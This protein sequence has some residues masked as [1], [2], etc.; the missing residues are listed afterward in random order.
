MKPNSK[1]NHFVF[2]VGRKYNITVSSDDGH[3]NTGSGAVY[4]GASGDDHEFIVDGASQVWRHETKF[5][6]SG[7]KRFTL[8]SASIKSGG[9]I[10]HNIYAN[11]VN[12][13]YEGLADDYE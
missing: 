10:Y 6:D 5:Y 4:V 9:G 13:E 8:Q 3:T 7:G 1:N 12:N 11:N 2:E